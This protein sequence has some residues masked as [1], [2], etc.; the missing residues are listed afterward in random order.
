MI[1]T[2][3]L[4]VALVL[5]P[6]GRTVGDVLKTPFSTRE[7]CEHKLEEVKVKASIIAMAMARRNE[8]FLEI[9]ATRCVPLGTNS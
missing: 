3:F 8:P 7:E 2:V 1:G 5:L 9:V 6:D 4:G